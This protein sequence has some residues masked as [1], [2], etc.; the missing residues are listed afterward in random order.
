MTAC[1]CQPNSKPELARMVSELQALS[2][3]RHTVFLLERIH[4]TPGHVHDSVQMNCHFFST[5][6]Q[7]RFAHSRFACTGAEHHLGV[8][9]MPRFNVADNV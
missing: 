8:D 5:I 3:K 4:R 7:R 1:C 9:V 2:R 6:D